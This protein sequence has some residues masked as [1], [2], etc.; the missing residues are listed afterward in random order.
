MKFHQKPWTYVELVELKVTNLE[1]SLKFYEEVIGFKVLN[2][3]ANNT[4]NKKFFF[5]MDL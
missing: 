4:T 3:A 2:N 5:M 1:Q